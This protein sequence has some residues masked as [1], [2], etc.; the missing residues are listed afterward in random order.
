MTAEANPFLGF[1]GR[2][3][4]ATYWVCFAILASSTISLFV[5]GFIGVTILSAATSIGSQQAIAMVQRN[6]QIMTLL[7]ILGLAYPMAT[8]AAKRLHDIGLSGW[9]SVILVV[10]PAVIV[11]LAIVG[12]IAPESDIAQFLD[13]V[14]LVLQLL[15]I[16]ILGAMPGTRGPNAYGE[17]PI[18]PQHGSE[19]A[20]A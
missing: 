20:L 17:S 12:V 1:E 8:S 7:V 15:I 6:A 3:S 4:R 5:I 16:A 19:P 13:K 14:L 11:M 2:I 18:G 9:W 10:P